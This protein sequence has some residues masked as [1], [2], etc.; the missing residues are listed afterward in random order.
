MQCCFLFLERSDIAASWHVQ[1]NVE[2]L[3]SPMHIREQVDFLSVHVVFKQFNKFNKTDNSFYQADISTAS[4]CLDLP[5]YLTRTSNLGRQAC[6][7]NVYCILHAVWGAC[8]LPHLRIDRSLPCTRLVIKSACIE[9][10]SF[11]RVVDA[12]SSLNPMPRGTA[13]K[14]SIGLSLRVRLTG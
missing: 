13:D 14:N 1:E 4:K 10:S 2:R 6:I 7:G 8:K 3:S 11:H 5:F 12:N 9:R